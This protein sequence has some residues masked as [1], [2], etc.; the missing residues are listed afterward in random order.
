MDGSMP[1]HHARTTSTGS[2]ALE[3]SASVWE[4]TDPT[5]DELEVLRRNEERLRLALAYA[6]IGVWESRSRADQ[7]I[8]SEHCGPLFGFPPGTSG[9]DGDSFLAL[10]HTDDR[11]RV[12]AALDRHLAEGS[13]YEVEFRVVWRDGTVRWLEAKARATQRDESGQAA[14]SLGVVFDI[15]ERKRADEALQASEERY[16]DVVEA[17]TDLVCRY[18]PDATLTFVNG[19]YCRFFGKTSEEL[20]GTSFLALIPEPARAAAYLQLEALVLNPRRHAYEHEVTHGD[21]TVRWQSWVD[22]PVF[23]DDG[24]LVEFQAIGHDITDR[25]LAE[26]RIR[27]AEARNR[28]ILE[29]L[30]DLMFV[31]TRD[32][33][34]LDGQGPSGEFLVPPEQFLGKSVREVLPPGVADQAL[35]CLNRAFETGEPQLLEYRLPVHGE[36]RDYEARVVPCGDNLL[37]IVRDI[38][39]R[40]RS[41][42]DLQWLT[43]RLLHS[44]DEERRRIARELHETTAQSLVAVSLNL[45]RASRMLPDGRTDVLASLAESRSLVEQVLRD[46]RTLSYVLH[47]PLL[48]HRG[49]AESL[50]WYVDGFVKRSGFDVELVVPKEL[51]PLPDS[52]E[53]AFLRIVQECLTN[54]HKHSGSD[55]AVIGLF[56]EEDRLVL[57][58]EDFGSGIAE[59]RSSTS[60]EGVQAVGVGIPGMRERLRQLGGHLDIVGDAGGTIVTASVPLAI[61]GGA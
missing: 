36:E 40:R 15:T 29:A 24:N 38:T 39:L 50:H 31:Q 61:N 30:P 6:G 53:T 26:E 20:I 27:E 14:A 19:A 16:R 11:G 22:L 59:T 49:L 23:D 48:D 41:Q 28:A 3:H 5:D 37:S 44:Q 55:R 2:D 43:G 42:E 10:V 7:A 1:T 8:W 12:A 45:A 47:P 52:V 58:V 9:I 21:G 17:Q 56:V 46:I 35:R 4:E 33:V 51:G 34:F 60:S 54:I 13:D 18:L 25:K 32:G 57:R